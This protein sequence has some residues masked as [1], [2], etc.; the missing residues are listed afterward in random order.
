MTLPPRFARVM[1]KQEQARLE[2][3]HR[4]FIRALPCAACGKPPPSE[5]A[6]VGFHGGLGPPSDGRCLVPLCGSET[7]WED[8]CHSRKHFQGADRF[9]AGLGIDARALALRLWRVSGDVRA[10]ERA[11]REARQRII[12]VRRYCPGANGP[13]RSRPAAAPRPHATPSPI[14]RV[15]VEPDHAAPAAAILL[16]CG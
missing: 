16:E 10:G 2:P 8:C 5:C 15:G 3:Q 9:W 7:V 11:I 14:W 6:S 13:M 12:T 1:A 4:D